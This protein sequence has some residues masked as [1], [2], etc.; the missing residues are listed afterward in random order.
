MESQCAGVWKCYL[1]QDSITGEDP[2]RFVLKDRQS[3]QNKGQ[4]GIV[5]N[6]WV[7]LGQW[8]NKEE[9]IDGLCGL[10]QGETKGKKHFERHLAGFLHS[11]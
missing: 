1:R 6:K 8:Q 2:K 9:G 7:E 10:G 5:L 11:E 4:C 3:F